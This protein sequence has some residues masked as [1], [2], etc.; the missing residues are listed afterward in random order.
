MMIAKNFRDF[1][2]E[3][4][5]CQAIQQSNQPVDLP[6]RIKNREAIRVGWLLA[7]RSYALSLL[8]ALILYGIQ[9]TVSAESQLVN[10]V[11]SLVQAFMYLFLLSPWVVRMMVRKAFQGFRIRIVRCSS[12][13]STGAQQARGG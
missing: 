11:I 2:F 5:R 3:V 4:V 13:T 6:R 12:E 1:H 7:W 8:I 9:L 10:V